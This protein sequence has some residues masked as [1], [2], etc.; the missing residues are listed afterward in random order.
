MFSVAWLQYFLSLW[1][2]KR[3][4]KC[5]DF[6]RPHLQ[7]FNHYNHSQW[8][9]TI[10]AIIQSLQSYSH[11]N[12]TIIAIIAIISI[13]ALIVIIAII[14]II[15]AVI[16]QGVIIVNVPFSFSVMPTRRRTTQVA[17][18]TFWVGAAESTRRLQTRLCSGEV[19]VGCSSSQKNIQWDLR[20]FTPMQ[21]YININSGVTNYLIIVHYTALQY[22]LHYNGKW[23]VAKV[24]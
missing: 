24:L 6:E 20:L 1:K 22:K 14:A 18:D 10:I 11:C 21:L 5:F 15:H 3:L 8:N 9:H 19:H 4:A 2:C 23:F 17:Q 13:I 16:L 7:S 12:H